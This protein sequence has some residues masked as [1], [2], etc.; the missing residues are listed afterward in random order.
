MALDG[1]KTE[2]FVE[3][4]LE[5]NDRCVP[6]LMQ[7]AANVLDDRR[8][9][10]AARLLDAVLAIDPNDRLVLCHRAAAAWL[11]H[12]HDAYTAFRARALAGD[13]GWPSATA[14]SA[15]TCVRCT[16]SPTR[17]RSTPPRTS[18]IPTT[19]RRCTGSRARWSTPARAQAKELLDRARQKAQGLVDPWRE[20]RVGGAGP[21]R[22]RGPSPPSAAIS[23]SRCTTT[24]SRCS[25]HYLVPLQLEAAQVLGAKYQ[26]KPPQ[27]GKIEVFHTWDDFSVRA[28]GFRGFTAL[29]ACSAA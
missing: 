4:V 5:R 1:G 6:A 10:D 9:R 27:P 24:T 21:A 25:T 13:P 16:G 22:H 18:P 28:I 17:C 7:R 26:W 8:Y 19:S 14:S 12:D 29:G 15:T 2:R 20:Q 11:L 3:R 23:A